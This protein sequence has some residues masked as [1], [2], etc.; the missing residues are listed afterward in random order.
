MTTAARPEVA[1]APGPVGARIPDSGDGRGGLH[2]D[3]VEGSRRRDHRPA[4]ATPR[5]SG[6]IVRPAV[7]AADGDERP[8]QSRGADGAVQSQRGR[9]PHR[10]SP[11]RLRR[12]RT[13]PDREITVTLRSP[14][15]TWP[16]QG[17]SRAAEGGVHVD[18]SR[19]C[20][21][22]WSRARSCSCGSGRASSKGVRPRG[23]RS[24]SRVE[25]EGLTSAGPEALATFDEWRGGC[26]LSLAVARRIIERAR[27][28]GVWS[29]PTAPRPPRC[30]AAPR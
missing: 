10:C 9:S 28:R 8:L 14:T 12:C 20:V 22:S 2:P 16:V 19:R 24:R 3:A 21:A 4:A 5:G 15:A 27:R 18:S 6:E 26:G 30:R 7:G 1:P 17:R 25:I 11:K 13:L 29:P 23:S